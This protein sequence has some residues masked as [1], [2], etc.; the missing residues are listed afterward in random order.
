MIRYVAQCV[1]TEDGVRQVVVDEADGTDRRQH[2][3]RQ[4]H[5]CGEVPYTTA[6]ATVMAGAVVRSRTFPT[7]RSMVSA[8]CAAQSPDDGAV[9][10]VSRLCRTDEPT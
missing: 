8:A 1:L 9:L 5:E 7:A 4:P 3:G 6:R 10:A 2:Q